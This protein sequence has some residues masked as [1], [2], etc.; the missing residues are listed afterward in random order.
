V[1]FNMHFTSF[2][3]RRVAAALG[4]LLPLTLR[5]CR[6]PTVV[7]IHNLVD[8]T[9]LEAAGYAGRGLQNRLLR[10][11][12]TI[13]TRF[14]LRANHVVTTMPEY[15][16]ILRT[17][18]GARNVSLTPHGA[19]ECAPLPTPRA[20]G[21][22]PLRLLAFGKFGTYKRVDDLVEAYRSLIDAG[23]E[24]ELVIAGTDSPVT[25]GYLDGVRERCH[26]LPGVQFTGYVEEDD[27][28]GLFEGCDIVVFPYTGTT[29]SSGPLHQ[30]G[31]YA[32]PVVA[33]RIGDFVDLILEEGYVAET[34]RAG[35]PTSLAAALDELLDDPARREAMGVQNHAAASGLPLADIA[36]WHVAHLRNVLTRR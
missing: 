28:A 21:T 1:L 10:M 34:F 24:V 9:D 16:E 26:D 33:P 35:D 27:V 7:L 22:S 19:F 12:G 6:I 30:A 20:I 13:L 29:G 23:R 8:T 3:S 25:P 5:V 36:D 11:I 18:Y 2:G 14:V 17:R 15:V 32:R 31:S 4:L